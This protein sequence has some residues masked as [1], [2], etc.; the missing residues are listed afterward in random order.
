MIRRIDLR[1]VEK[2]PHPVV[3]RAQVDVESVIKTVKPIIED[4]K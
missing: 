4:V 1:K 3:Q 2:L